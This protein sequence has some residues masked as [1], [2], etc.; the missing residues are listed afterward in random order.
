MKSWEVGCGRCSA[1]GR[2]GLGWMG[3]GGSIS[4]GYSGPFRIPTKSSKGL[5]ILGL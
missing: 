1:M 4:E 5:R 3:I 2:Y